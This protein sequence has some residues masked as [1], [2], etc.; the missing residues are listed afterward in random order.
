MMCVEHLVGVAWIDCTDQGFI[1]DFFWGGEFKKEGRT[2]RNIYL[3]TPT[4]R[5]HT[6]LN[7]NRLRS[8]VSDINLGRLMRIA[9]E[10]PQL[11]E[12]NFHQILDIY[13]QQNHRIPL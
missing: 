6:L 10:G 11:S 3:T 7:K 13:K 8:R 2:Q 12:V 5:N 9:I 4:F 1:R